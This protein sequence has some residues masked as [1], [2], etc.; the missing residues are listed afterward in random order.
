ME[1]LLPV[2]I[3]IVN[4]LIN[5]VDELPFGLDKNEMIQYAMKQF[6]IRMSLLERARG[7]SPKDLSSLSEETMKTVK[8]EF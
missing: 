8:E 5:Q 3:G 7:K 1:F 4:E 2:A 6:D